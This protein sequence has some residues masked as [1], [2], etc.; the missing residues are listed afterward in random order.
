MNVNE[1]LGEKNIDEYDDIMPILRLIL[2]RSGIRGKEGIFGTRERGKLYFIR[3]IWYYCLKV[4]HLFEKKEKSVLLSEQIVCLD[5]YDL[6]LYNILNKNCITIMA[7]Y[8][9]PLR[10]EPKETVVALK[11]KSQKLYV[12][13][14]VPGKKLSIVVE[15]TY[16]LL[17]AIILKKEN[18]S[19]YEE[20]CRSL[21][22]KLRKISQK[23]IKK[24]R[25]ELKREGVQG[26]ITNN[27]YN[28]TDVVLLMA[29][30]QEKILTKELRHHSD[31]VVSI[32]DRQCS[33]RNNAGF[34]ENSVFSY[35]D[36][37]LLWSEYEKKYWKKY[38]HLD[39][40]SLKKVCCIVAGCPE[41]LDDELLKLKKM[42]P[43]RDA[44]TVFVPSHSMYIKD[45]AKKKITENDLALAKESRKQIFAAVEQYAA[46]NGVK[47]IYVRYHPYEDERFIKNDEE[48]TKNYNVLSATREDFY[49]AMC[50]SKV[51]IGTTSSSLAVAL[52]FGCKCISLML[53]EEKYDFCGAPIASMTIE[54]IASNEEGM[55]EV[56]QNCAKGIDISK[57]LGIE[58][59]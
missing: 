57:L 7:K 45:P 37:I 10:R 47:E 34:I 59:C 13:D 31:M 27:Q 54:Q 36:Q 58:V 19:S 16:D 43:K 15:E 41:M 21:F 29:C 48:I 9:C 28:L 50:V 55:G 39:D 5:R 51:V 46:K 42:Y 12:G 53:K 17:N 6:L 11:K 24:I 20:E 2:Y 49:K 35:V 26:F 52:L 23:R 18:C 8:N 44:I 4:R 22:E 25:K 40:I 32:D 14:S 3:T 33:K 30:D 1:F 38:I 56:V